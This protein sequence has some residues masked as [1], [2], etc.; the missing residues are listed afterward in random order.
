MEDNL[1]YFSL[2]KSSEYAFNTI[3][4]LIIHL[5]CF[6][7]CYYYYQALFKKNLPKKLIEDWL[8]KLFE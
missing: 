6:L 1:K 7:P 4:S 5:F 8:G 3:I 2:I